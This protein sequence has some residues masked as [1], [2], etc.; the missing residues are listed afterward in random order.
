MDY[1]LGILI[2]KNVRIVGPFLVFA[3]SLVGILGSLGWITPDQADALTKFFGATTVLLASW[4]TKTDLDGYTDWINGLD[5]L[6]KE[7]SLG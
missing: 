3:G 5:T 2:A 6:V 7:D 4:V 1:N